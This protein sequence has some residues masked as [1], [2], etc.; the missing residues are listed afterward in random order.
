MKLVQWHSE[1]SGFQSSYEHDPILFR[2]E[3]EKMNRNQQAALMQQKVMSAA[4]LNNNNLSGGQ[5]QIPSG[6]SDYSNPQSGLGSTGQTIVNGVLKG[7]FF[8]FNHFAH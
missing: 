2:L 3:M 1:I 7:L 5:G 6:G 8:I 4:G